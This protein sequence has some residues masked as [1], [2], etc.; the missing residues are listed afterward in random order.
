MPEPRSR[1]GFVGNDVSTA[2]LH[3]TRDGVLVTDGSGR[4]V[5]ANEVAEAMLGFEPGELNGT[6]ARDVLFQSN[7]AN[8]GHDPETDA[9]H[10]RDAGVEHD[11]DADVEHDP[12]GR[13]GQIGV[14]R[15]K[16]GAPL[17]VRYNV[18]PFAGSE[19]TVT[20]SVVSF[21]P[22]AESVA[23]EAEGSRVG[24]GPR[25]QLRE[26]GEDW[27]PKRE[28]GQVRKGQQEQERGVAVLTRHQQLLLSVVE[29]A[30][31]MVSTANRDGNLTYVNKV[32]REWLGLEDGDDVTGTPLSP[33]TM[34][35]VQKAA[36]DG[37]WRGERQRFL[38][39]MP[40]AGPERIVE[41]T[42]IAHKDASGEI[43]SFSTL[44]VDITERRETAR[45]RARLLAIIEDTPNFVATAD[46]DGRITYVNRT[47]RR[48][49]GLTD[50]EPL[51]NVTI[52]NFHTPQSA[53]LV[54]EEGFVVAAREGVWR[55]ETV[56][57][58]PGGKEIPTLQVIVCH[59][60][61]NGEVEYYS[62]IRQDIGDRKSMEERLQ[63][64]ASHDPLTGV[65][66]R[67]SFLEELRFEL[68]RTG[69][70]GQQGA[71]LYLDLD[72][73]KEI[74]DS[75]GHHAGDE[76]LKHVVRLIRSQLREKDRLARIGG[77]EFAVL[78]PHTSPQAAKGVGR[79]ILTLLEDEVIRLGGD[80]VQVRSSIG[81]AA[82]PDHATTAE[83]L[84]V[85]ADWAMYEAKR[86]GG[87]R[88]SL[89]CPQ[90]AG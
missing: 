73:F 76:T 67:V 11:A 55:G 66:N 85:H 40:G 46:K 1:G 29:N 19:G 89:F 32:G 31:A 25:E 51:E 15:C 84:L 13:R 75:F 23:D 3:V 4:I 39:D 78:L 5:F 16:D 62:T 48:L 2:L 88:L 56:L 49:L 68:K 64:L 26:Q 9:E 34:E 14:F 24:V 44:V 33:S 30:P 82:Y 35:L 50:D 41:Q 70:H 37:I 61:S 69:P 72:D 47:G 36:E 45:E 87:G 86:S 10:N 7:S 58:V 90:S 74:N 81:L 65:L 53:R 43:E 42:I 59:K 83:E 54:L 77:D 38:A 80:V 52:R 63:Y 17:A 79:R 18:E 12:Q 6:A 28:R 21:W 71:V 27:A 57:P 60:D 22:G 20:G 8:R